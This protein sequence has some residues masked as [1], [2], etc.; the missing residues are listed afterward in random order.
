MIAK[1]EEWHLNFLF[2]WHAF[3]NIYHVFAV[4]EWQWLFGSWTQDD[5]RLI[6]AFIVYFWTVRH[7]FSK[8]VPNQ[9]RIMF[10]A[11]HSTELNLTNCAHHSQIQKHVFWVINKVGRV[12]VVVADVNNTYRH[13]FAIN[14]M[15]EVV[16][17]LAN[18][19]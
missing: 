18:R 5:S 9:I 2:H 15:I 6:V 19:D 14:A 11:N 4:Y 7:H 13:K 12:E 16:C 17:S 10:L 8:L 3:V 1:L